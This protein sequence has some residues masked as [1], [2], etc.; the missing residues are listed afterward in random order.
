MADPM[1]TMEVEM[2]VFIRK[3]F[4]DYLMRKQF[5]DNTIRYIETKSLFSSQFLIHGHKDSLQLML[6]DINRFN[7]GVEHGSTKH[8]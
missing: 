3:Q 1:Q 7:E 5:L 4:R 2:G 8:T 6:H